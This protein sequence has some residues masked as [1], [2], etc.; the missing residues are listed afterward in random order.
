MSILSQL[1]LNIKTKL[2]VL[3]P[4]V[5]PSQLIHIYILVSLIAT[6]QN[7]IYR[8]NYRKQ[9]ILGWVKLSWY[10]QYMDFCGDTFAVQGQGAI[11][12]Y[13]WSK[14][15]IGKTFVV[16]RKLRKFSPVKLSLFTV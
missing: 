7:D 9:E 3:K 2:N 13:T 8:V 10:L 1:A 15:F 4:G 11:Y 6:I 14:R 16:Q 5:H 12:V